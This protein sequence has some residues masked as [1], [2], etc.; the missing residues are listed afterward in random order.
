MFSSKL[1]NIVKLNRYIN[2]KTFAK[3]NVSFQCAQKRHKSDLYE[4]DYLISM[5]PDE[6]VYNLINLQLKSYDFTLLESCQ[7]EI[8]RYAEVMGIEVEDGWATP[9]Q[10]LKIQRFKPNS[11]AMESEYHLNVYERNVQVSDVPAWALGTL[12]RVSRALLPEGCT[13]NVH[14]HT[15][16]HDEIRYV[17]DNDLIELKQQ[18]EEMGGSRAERKKKK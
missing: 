2:P 10:Q 17:P 14:E 11:T 3:Q 16:A 18:L 5:Q 9:A 8:H 1:L 6:P 13:L 15:Q 12:L 4:P 7:K